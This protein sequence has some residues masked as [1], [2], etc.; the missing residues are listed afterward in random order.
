MRILHVI[1]SLQ[2]GGAER[3]CIDIC[4]EIAGRLGHELILATLNDKIEH[5]ISNK[6]FK[7]VNTDSIYTPSITGKP[8]IKLEGLEDLIDSFYPDVIHSHLF[9]SEMAT[10]FNIRP[11]VTYIS[12]CHDNMFQ[13]KKPGLDS[14]FDKTKF[15]NL[16]ERNWILKKYEECNN[17]FIAI[18]RDTYN[19]FTQN[20]PPNLAKR[21]ILHPNAVNT[22]QFAYPEREF[23]AKIPK[24]IITIG[25]LIPRKNHSFLLDI[26]KSLIDSN[27][28]VTIQILGK[29]PELNNLQEKINSLQLQNLVRI[30]ASPTIGPYLKKADL[31]VHVAINEPFGLVLVEAGAAGL[32]IVSLDGKGNRDL[33][34]NNENGYLI[35]YQDINQF[36]E[37]IKL[38]LTQEELYNKMS[39]KAIE[40]AK[41]FD[42]KS[43]V[44]KLLTI[45][46]KS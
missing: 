19:Y 43:Y 5:D 29:G 45:Y 31:Y 8:T 12:H 30:E 9:Q 25:S 3:I 10:R 6:K 41:D 22:V 36:C 4:E 44:D 32:P 34:H 46:A 37:K 1:P 27:F 21:V 2:L 39:K 14:I 42:I 11:N 26:A 24:N 7:I 17:T 20:L 13:L 40:I 16:F 38:I 23:N 15:T 28:Q 33:I 18:S 35:E